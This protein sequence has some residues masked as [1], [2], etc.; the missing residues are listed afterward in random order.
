MQSPVSARGTGTQHL[1]LPIQDKV[2]ETQP[3]IGADPS[4]GYDRMFLHAFELD[5]RYSFYHTRF[6]ESTQYNQKFILFIMFF[7]PGIFKST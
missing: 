5:P 2:H 4:L 1:G 7:K 6:I 3:C